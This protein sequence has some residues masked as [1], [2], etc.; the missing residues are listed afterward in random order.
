M[1]AI[2]L[3]TG[4]AYLAAY[5]EYQ[6]DQED[7]TPLAT[8]YYDADNPDADQDGIGFNAAWEAIIAALTPRND[9]QRVYLTGG[10]AENAPDIDSHEGTLCP[11]V[12]D[13]SWYYMPATHTFKPG[14]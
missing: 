4:S 14:R 12:D 5:F 2:T 6:V 7:P 10:P 1:D 8:C 9:T 11:N 13:S 3:A